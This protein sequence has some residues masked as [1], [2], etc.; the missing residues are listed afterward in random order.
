[1]NVNSE[2]AWI[3]AVPARKSQSAR[4]V[5]RAD[6]RNK[7]SD[8]NGTR[9][10]YLTVVS[11]RFLPPRR[12]HTT[13]QRFGPPA[14]CCARSPQAPGKLR[15]NSL[16]HIFGTRLGESGA[17]AFTTMRLM[18]H[19]TVTVSQRYVHQTYFQRARV[20]KSADAKDSKVRSG[21]SLFRAK[22]ETVRAW[23]NRQTHRT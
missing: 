1:M 16:R 18:G 12:R 19:S 13:K 7:V 8:N 14:R 10:V 11:G 21:Q 5:K 3:K 20:A 6:G 4:E 17:D 23:R 15:A 22:F 9:F 2:D